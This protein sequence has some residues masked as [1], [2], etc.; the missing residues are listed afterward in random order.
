MFAEWGLIILKEDVN[1]YSWIPIDIPVLDKIGG[2][3]FRVQQ[4]N[5][6]TYF[7]FCLRLP[8]IHCVASSLTRNVGT[9]AK[10]ILGI[11]IY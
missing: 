7:V 8:C 2:Q 6:N 11:A 1:T 10:H 4:Y 3:E 9:V 5:V